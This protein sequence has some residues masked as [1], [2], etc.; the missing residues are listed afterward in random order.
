[1]SFFPPRIDLAQRCCKTRQIDGFEP[2]ISFNEQTAKS[3]RS[4]ITTHSYMY[5]NDLRLIEFSRYNN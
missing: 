1:M 3:M 4:L 2:L 5:G